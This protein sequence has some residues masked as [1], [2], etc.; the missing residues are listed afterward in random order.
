MRSA[1]LLLVLA[2][3]IVTFHAAAADVT[4]RALLNKDGTTD[5]EV[6]S[7]TTITKVHV[8][9]PDGTAQN[10]NSVYT[11]S[12]S[13]RLQA[14][15][16]RNAQI[17]VQVSVRDTVAARTQVVEQ[18]VAVK[19]RPDLEVTIYGPKI[20]ARGKQS[21]VR[22]IA[23]ELNWD[24]DVTATY[25]LFVDDVAAGT[26]TVFEYGSEYKEILFPVTFTHLGE[27][28]LRVYTDHETP[29]DWDEAN[30]T[31][32]LIADVRE[33]QELRFGGWHA[34]AEEREFQEHFYS[35]YPFYEET[36]DNS[37]VEQ[38]FALTATF[39]GT[40]D[41]TSIQLRISGTTAAALPLFDGAGA[42]WR[43]RPTWS[44]FCAYTEQGVP[45]VTVCYDADW[46]YTRVEVRHAVADA[47]YHSVG[48]STRDNPW[49]PE[50]PREDW[51]RTT[52]V[53][54]LKNRFLASVEMKIEMSAG[55]KT[56]RAEPLIA[57]GAPV[58]DGRDEPYRCYYDDFIGY[59]V[60]SESH[61]SYKTR[62]GAA[63]AG[64]TP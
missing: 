32:T 43:T 55:E 5:L 29:A 52:E 58:T 8:E 36:R 42:E 4:T 46:D 16:E 59:D 48:W 24:T 9:F 40:F 6:T 31:S 34:T 57:P 2:S 21:Y 10:F 45:E 61:T 60:C 39:R 62:S 30:N 22:V 41:P 37:G 56:W 11:S 53:H 3:L 27:T 15:L 33:P 64:P 35:K 23:R 26:Q 44:G 63:D 51:D 54:T 12:F 50:R 7:A 1:K 13:G 38:Q 25:H 18:T 19:R 14:Q 49:A 17:L 28:R 20:A 47:T